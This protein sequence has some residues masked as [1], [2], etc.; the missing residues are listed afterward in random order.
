MLAKKY[1][2]SSEENL[3]TLVHQL[4]MTIKTVANHELEVFTISEVAEILKCSERTV[5]H[6][7]YESHDLRYF[8][9][10]REVRVRRKDLVSFIQ[11]G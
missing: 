11:Q 8:K 4:T 1:D 7:L 6:H 5:K 3:K 9:A 10:G 2:E